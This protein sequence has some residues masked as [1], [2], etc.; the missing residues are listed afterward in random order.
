M[1]TFKRTGKS[2]T[3]LGVGL[4]HVYREMW[5]EKMPEWYNKIN[6]WAN[7]HN[8]SYDWGKLD[9]ETGIYHFYKILFDQEIEDVYQIPL[10]KL[11]KSLKERKEYDDQLI[12]QRLIEEKKKQKEYDRMKAAVSEHAKNFQGL[13]YITP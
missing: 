6:D 9:F 2:N 8:I 1:N 11:L 10:P 3:S 7:H 13:P 4:V 12:M 5:N